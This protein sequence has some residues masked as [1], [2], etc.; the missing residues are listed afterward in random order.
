MFV[1]YLEESKA[2]RLYNPITKKVYVKRNV[3]CNEN[4]NTSINVSSLDIDQKESESE[5][6]EE[7]TP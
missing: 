3:K 1:A 6:Y 2:Q 5:R 4:K 7:Y